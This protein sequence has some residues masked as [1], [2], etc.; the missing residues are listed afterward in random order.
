MDI[1]AFLKDRP[2]INLSGLARAAKVP[3]NKLT[4]AEYE[5]GGKVYKRKLTP[6]QEQRVIAALQ[7]LRDALGCLP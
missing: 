7:V 4:G 3:L 6:D 1:I 2:E 5:K